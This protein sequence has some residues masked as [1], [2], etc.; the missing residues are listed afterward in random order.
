MSGKFVRASKFRHVYGQPFKKELCYEN[1]KPTLSAFDSNIIQSNGKY[2]SLNSN[3]I[4]SFTV[5]PIDEVGKAPDK[6]PMFRGHSGGSVLD[7][8][9]DPFDDHK[10][11]SSGEDGKILIWKI[12]NDYSY[13]NVDPDN[14]IDVSPIDSLIGHSRKVGHLQF[15]PCAKDVIASSSFDYTVKIWNINDKSCKLT[16]QHK[17]LVTSF[18]FNHN[19]TKIATASRDKKIRVWNSLTGELL[20]EGP[21]HL[22]AKACRIIWL[23]NTNRLVTTGFDRFSERQVALWNSDDISKG[24][25]GGFISIDSSSGTLMP[26]FDPSTNLLFIAGKGDG[27]VRYFEFADD[28]L[29]LLSEYPSTEAQRGFAVSP[30]RFV[31]IK[32]NE[33]IRAYK[34]TNDNSIEPLSFIVPRRSEM[35]Q[36]DI[37]PNAPSD[38]P[39]LTADEFFAGKTVDGPILC[40]MRDIYEGITPTLVASTAEVKEEKEETPKSAAKEESPKS[41][42]KEESPKPAFTQSQEQGVEKMFNE[43]GVNKLLDKVST[44]SDDDTQDVDADKNDEWG[45][46]S[47]TSSTIKESKKEEPKKEELKKEE[48]KKEELKKEEPKKEEPKKEEPKK[49][50]LKKEE[51]KKEELKKEEPKKEEPKK[52]E[53]KKEEPKEEEPKEEEPKPVIPSTPSLSASSAKSATS[54]AAATGLKANLERLH[55]LVSSLEANVDQLTKANLAKDDRLKALEE[56]IDLLLKK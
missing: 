42:S 24:C 15:H 7:T 17:D 20:S 22:G 36:D 11:L 2:I 29:H 43:K 16:L 50:E 54:G 28:D 5:I 52:E 53:P 19:G 1:L 23:G 4:G 30:K 31:N 33:I 21:G 39:A 34:L 18:C 10:I 48:P 44:L 13:T 8:A 6:V 27:N 32:E 56:K 41:V 38:K 9:F 35:F 49:E 26:F 12:P 3:G 25:I 45:S 55:N 51:P 37:Y 47:T 46:K 14:I 40:S